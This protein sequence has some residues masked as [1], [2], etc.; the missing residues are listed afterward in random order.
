MPE[1]LGP[2][3]KATR[4]IERSELGSLSRGPEGTGMSGSLAAALWSPLGLTMLI[5][6]LA[7][8]A[9]HQVGLEALPSVCPFLPL[10]RDLTVSVSCSLVSDSL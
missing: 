9:G 3:L 10:P 1:D 7:R 5:L 2:Y 6:V 8:G 4:F